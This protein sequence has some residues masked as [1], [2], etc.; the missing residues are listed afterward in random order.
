[1]S[2]LQ[3]FD[4]SLDMFLKCLLS[5]F[6]LPFVIFAW[7]ILHYKYKLAPSRSSPDESDSCSVD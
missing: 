6:V 3:D 2:G 5:W 4:W 1:M 7:P